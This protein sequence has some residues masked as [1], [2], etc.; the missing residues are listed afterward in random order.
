MT[1]LLAPAVARVALVAYALAVAAAVLAPSP[2][3]AVR[4][5]E[6]GYRGAQRLGLS[7]LLTPDRVES[8][9]NVAIFV[10]VAAL[11][12]LAFRRWSWLEWVAVATVAAEAVE[13]VQRVL[14]PQRSASAHDVVANSVGALL[15]AILG[16]VLRLYRE[17]K[18]VL[19]GYPQED[20]RAGI[21]LPRR[22][23]SWKETP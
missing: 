2:A 15:G 12:V 23:A 16:A 8:L 5:V 13:L 14:L 17:H 7:A 20:T 3:A 18:I 1:R 6:L 11:G 22:D 10:P 19:A 21:D 4:A 9:L